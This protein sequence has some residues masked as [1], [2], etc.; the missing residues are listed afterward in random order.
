MKY[1]HRVSHYVFLFN[2]MQSPSDYAIFWRLARNTFSE[3]YQ[4]PYV[5]LLNHL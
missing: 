1:G 2:Y 5:K 3:L 4:H